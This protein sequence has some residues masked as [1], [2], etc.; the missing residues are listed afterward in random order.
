MQ[1]H[2]KEKLAR[3]DLLVGTIV[4]L[5]SP[6]IAEIFCGAGFDWLFVDLEHSTLSIKDAQA[7]LQA[8]APKVPCVV[9]IPSNDE[10]WIKKA[11]DIGS[12]GIIVPQVRTAEE[13]QRAVRFCKYPPAGSRSVGIARA[14]GYGQKFQEYVATA[15]DETAVI[16]QIEHIDAVKNLEKILDVSGIDCLFVGPYDL[17]AS[18]GKIGDIV[19]AEVQDAIS[20]VKKCAE[21]AKMPLGIFGASAEAVKPHIDNGYTLIAVGIDTLLLGNAARS[22]IA[23]V[24][25][26]AV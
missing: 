12:S 7:I 23:A 26:T 16:I 13:A 24:K 5:P 20:Q 25:A 10:V 17:S 22:I 6:E 8:A 18:M 2:F 1:E 4:T 3:Q 21:K 11:L 9:R 19:H 14:Q 15:N